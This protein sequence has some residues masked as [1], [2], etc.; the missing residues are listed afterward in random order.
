MDSINPPLILFS[1]FFSSTIFFIQSTYLVIALIWLISRYIS[2][3]SQNVYAL[4]SSHI[5]N[6][7]ENNINYKV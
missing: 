6:K 3:N 5:I 7:T 4:S 1:H 2:F